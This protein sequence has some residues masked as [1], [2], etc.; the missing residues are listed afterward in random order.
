[1]VPLRSD[2]FSL[3]GIACVVSTE[4]G[5]E[6]VCHTSLVDPNVIQQWYSWRCAGGN[7]ICL[8]KRWTAS[9][10]GDDQQFILTPPRCAIQN[11]HVHST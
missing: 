10:L 2:N 9:P 4:T 1:M 6:A 7:S 8:S 11:V 5:D 3:D